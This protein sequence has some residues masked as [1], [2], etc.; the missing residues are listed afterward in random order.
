MRDVAAQHEMVTDEIVMLV[1]VHMCR[2]LERSMG[3]RILKSKLRMHYIATSTCNIL[4]MKYARKCMFVQD[5]CL[6]V[7]M[8]D[9]ALANTVPGVMHT[10]WR[11]MHRA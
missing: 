9:K 3:E 1:N 10:A 5:S 2:I 8:H 7:F 6:C 4:R 11:V